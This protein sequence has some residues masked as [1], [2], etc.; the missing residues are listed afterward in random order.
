MVAGHYSVH[1]EARL[2]LCVSSMELLTRARMCSGSAEKRTPRACV[3]LRAEL[4]MAKSDYG[5]LGQAVALT[6][7]RATWE[8]TTL[9]RDK[10]TLT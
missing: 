4:K 8:G 2:E 1:H 3:R 9:C 5:K 7:K 10:E 6:S